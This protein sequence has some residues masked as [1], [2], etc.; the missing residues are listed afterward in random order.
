MVHSLLR[1]F[2]GKKAPSVS[3]QAGLWSALFEDAEFLNTAPRRI[4]EVQGQLSNRLGRAYQLYH[5]LGRQY[6]AILEGI[7]HIADL[8][9]GLGATIPS[10]GSGE[11]LRAVHRAALDLLEEH[12]VQR[13]ERR[14]G[15]AEFEGCEIVGFSERDDLADGVIGGLV[16][17][18]YRFS[19]GEVLR[20]AR[21]LVN[22]RPPAPEKAERPASL[23]EK[24]ALPP[25]VS[26]GE[27]PSE[28][29]PSGG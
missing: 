17:P 9:E 5:R 16:A 12:D 22:R 28:P 21:V 11:G 19:S 6:G 25:S 29:H 23:V 14:V 3:D 26:E 4:Q 7:I 27:V 10:D 15:E 24:E 20:R 18:G 1:F 2:K 13:W 8:C